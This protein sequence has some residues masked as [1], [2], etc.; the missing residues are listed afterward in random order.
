[1]QPTLQGVDVIVLQ[2]LLEGVVDERQEAVHV[3]PVEGAV[4]VQTHRP[5]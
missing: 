1:M 3:D 5:A 4:P 2:S